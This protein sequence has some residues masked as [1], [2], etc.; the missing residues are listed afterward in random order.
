[1]NILLAYL[2][3]TNRTNPLARPN[4]QIYDHLPRNLLSL[5]HCILMQSDV[6]MDEELIK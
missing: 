6:A 5:L 1:M 2:F 3:V 4:L